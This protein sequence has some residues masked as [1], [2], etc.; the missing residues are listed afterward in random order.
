MYVCKT[1]T[2]EMHVNKTKNLCK[3][4]SNMVSMVTEVHPAELSVNKCI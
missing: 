2:V 4:Q 3:L 1:Q